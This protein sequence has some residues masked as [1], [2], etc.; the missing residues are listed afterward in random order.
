MR[1]VGLAL[2]GTG[3]AVSAGQAGAQEMSPQLAEVAALDARLLAGPTAT[4]ALSKWCADH[5]AADSRIRAE[6]DRAT[7]HNPSAATY[8]R[9]HA[10]AGDRIG[11]RRVKLMCGEHVL[12]IAENWYV[13]TRLTPEMVRALDET[14]TPFG[15]VIAPLLPRRQNL[16]DTRLWDGKGDAP[17][18]LLRHRALVS[19]GKGEPLAEVIETY[20]RGV[21]EIR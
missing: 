18:E 16:E 9:L 11:Y 15:T 10:G 13:E 1:S 4:L 3:I 2:I 6:V 20:Q 14:D 5:G 21:L 8:F 7:T 17:A 12:S 19:S